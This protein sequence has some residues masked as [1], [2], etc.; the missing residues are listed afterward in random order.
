MMSPARTALMK[1]RSFL[2][3]VTTVF[4][5]ALALPG[6]VLLQA[7]GT[8]SRKTASFTAP[9]SWKLLWS[10]NCANVGSASAFIVSVQTADGPRSANASVVQRGKRGSGT[11]QYRHGGTFRLP[12]TTRC[13]WQVTAKK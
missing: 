11:K 4:L 5:L 7:K 12:I 2:P 8:G 9:A 6:S 13:A 10:Y 1:L 3:L